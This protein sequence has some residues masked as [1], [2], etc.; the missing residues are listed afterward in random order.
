MKAKRGPNK[1]NSH[2]PADAPLG[3]R[4]GLARCDG[5][6]IDLV[7]GEALGEGAAGGA[8][9]RTARGRSG[10]GGRRSAG[11]GPRS[12][13]KVGHCYVWYGVCFSGVGLICCARCDAM[14]SW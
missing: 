8:G 5:R 13:G 3:L 2:V 7:D 12:A 9:G 4:Y 11:V 14:L 6:E 10:G 1:N